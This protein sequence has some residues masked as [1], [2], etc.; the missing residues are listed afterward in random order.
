MATCPVAIVTPGL[1][2][3]QSVFRDHDC[4]SYVPEVSCTS[5]K[6][7]LLLWIIT[8]ISIFFLIKLDSLTTLLINVFI[9]TDFY[10]VCNFKLFILLQM[11]SVARA[12]ILQTG[13]VHLNLQAT[14]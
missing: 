4:L 11:H 10:N 14:H 1:A 3:Q 8:R 13:P 2:V 7:M 9:Y 6:L 12:N 5:F